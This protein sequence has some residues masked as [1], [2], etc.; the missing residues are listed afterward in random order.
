[1]AQL[2]MLN[3]LFHCVLTMLPK[4]KLEFFSSDL[5]FVLQMLVRMEIQ[6]INAEELP[7]PLRAEALA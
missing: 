3:N 4:T 1:M 2:C 5:F 7:G 6:N